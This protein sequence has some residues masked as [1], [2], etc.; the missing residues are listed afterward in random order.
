MKGPVELGEVN[1][2]GKEFL[3]FLLLYEASICNTLFAKNTYAN[4]A[5]LKVQKMALHRLCSDVAEGQEEVLRCGSDERGRMS[6]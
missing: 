2:A 1:D 4:V 3:N 5:T 6:H